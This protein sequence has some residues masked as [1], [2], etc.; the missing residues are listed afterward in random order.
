VGVQAIAQVL[1]HPV[2]DEVRQVGLTDAEQT[3][4][5]GDGDHD[6]DERVEQTE[7]RSAVGEQRV[8]EYDL[9]EQ[10]VDDAQPGRDQ[11]RYE[12]QRSPAPVGL[13]QADDP[14]DESRP[15]FPAFAGQRKRR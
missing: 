13:K 11:D 12:D 2:A 9:D 6:R 10:R 1:H 15:R 14:L 8:V 5:D 4:D 3:R 7:V